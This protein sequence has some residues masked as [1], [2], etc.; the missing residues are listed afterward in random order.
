MKSATTRGQPLPNLHPVLVDDPQEVADQLDHLAKYFNALELASPDSMSRLA[1]K[2]EVKLMRTP[3]EPFDEP[4]GIP[5]VKECE[6]IY[7]LR[8]R[9]LFERLEGP[10]S[11]DEELDDAAP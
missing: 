2:L 9:N 6:Q 11:D 8:I 10:F 3:E 1:G 4:G 5:T 7:Y